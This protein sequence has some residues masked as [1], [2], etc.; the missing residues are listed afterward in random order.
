MKKSAEKNFKR[1]HRSRETIRHTNIKKQKRKIN[2]DSIVS[3]VLLVI[4][5]IIIELTSINF[6]LEWFKDVDVW[7]NDFFFDSLVFF[8]MSTFLSKIKN[9]YLNFGISF[10]LS[11]LLSNFIQL[12]TSNSTVTLTLI[13]FIVID[14][15]V[16]L[17]WGRLGYNR[18]KRKARKE[19]NKLEREYAQLI[20]NMDNKNRSMLYNL[21]G[22]IKKHPK[23]C[24]IIDA[25]GIEYIMEFIEDDKSIRKSISKREQNIENKQ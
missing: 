1:S 11:V 14:I 19:Q 10:V 12:D 7:I 6:D 3:F 23:E 24:A 15:A 4:L 8:V 17:L 20:L 22:F 13:I 5:F 25:I 21:K 9:E 2:P 16:L 18:G